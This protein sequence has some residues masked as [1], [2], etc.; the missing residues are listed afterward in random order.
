MEKRAVEDCMK[1]LAAA[2]MVK[3][4]KTEAL[5]YF[6]FEDLINEALGTSVNN[7]DCAGIYS[8]GERKYER[9]HIARKE[10]LETLELIQNNATDG[11]I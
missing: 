10:Y 4:S 9:W 11:E 7:S 6:Q 8:D 3:N 5:L 2:T 1:L